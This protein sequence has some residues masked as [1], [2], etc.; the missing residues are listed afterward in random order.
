MKN[1]QAL[2]CGIL[3]VSFV[4]MPLEFSISKEKIDKNKNILL[5]IFTGKRD[6]AKIRIP[7]IKKRNSSKGMLKDLG[8]NRSVKPSSIVQLPPKAKKLNDIISK[9]EKL[10]IG[11]VTPVKDFNDAKKKIDKLVTRAKKLRDKSK[12][13]KKRLSDRIN[14]QAGKVSKKW[15]KLLTALKDGKKRSIKD[16]HDITKEVRGMKGV[17]K[18]FDPDYGRDEL[19]DLR[20]YM[21]DDEE[22]NLKLKK[23]T[24]PIK[25]PNLTDLIDAMTGQKK[26]S[27]MFPLDWAKLMDEFEKDITDLDVEFAKTVKNL[28]DLRNRELDPVLVALK[29]AQDDYKRFR[30]MSTDATRLMR[31]MMAWRLLQAQLAQM[32]QAR[33]DLTALQNERAGQPSDR[34]PLIEMHPLDPAKTL[35]QVARMMQ[36]SGQPGSPFRDAFDLLTPE[37]SPH[38]FPDGIDY[39][40]L[41]AA[42]IDREQRNLRDI[43]RQRANSDKWVDEMDRRE[44]RKKA[45]ELL[46][47][48]RLEGKEDHPL[49]KG[50]RRAALRKLR[51]EQ[52]K[53]RDARIKKRQS[54]KQKE[55]D[56]L[57]H[58]LAEIYKHRDK[59]TPKDKPKKKQ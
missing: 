47:E 20:D 48:D 18:D 15:S 40:Q 17:D 16:W 12:R 33:D 43:H 50:H 46:R 41:S 10:K 14:R 26:P 13:Q 8:K 34:V 59:W 7:E 19:E 58:R 42:R 5:D 52:L 45:F 39:D 31:R 54:D 3:L 51:A 23:E 32:R 44:R 49:S 29:K 2:L 21:G 30:N 35:E 22:K 6:P 4:C 9:K 11:D 36:V 1:K 28:K 53:T 38:L 56:E 55:A 25:K 24:K 37:T 27:S 57:T